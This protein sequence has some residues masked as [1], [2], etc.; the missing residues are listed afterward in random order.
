VQ[1]SRPAEIAPE[2]T[3]AKTLALI[4]PGAS[5]LCAGDHAI[6]V[7]C[8]LRERGDRVWCVASTAEALDEATACGAHTRVAD[9]EHEPLPA[10]VGE[11]RFDVVVIAGVLEH[12]RE[13][14]RVLQP[15]RDVLAPGGIVVASLPNFG[16]AGVRLATQG[17]VV[18]PRPAVDDERRARVFTRSGIEALVRECG[19][20]VQTIDRTALPDADGKPAASDDAHALEFVV[21]AIPVPGPWDAGAMRALVH[22]L[23]AR[24]DDVREALREAERA[25]SDAAAAASAANADAHERA[26]AL[27]AAGEHAA[28]LEEERRAATDAGRDADRRAESLAEA[29]AAATAERDA[30]VARA[31]ASADEL[32]SALAEG[33]ARAHAADDAVRAAEDARGRAATAEDRAAAA[34]ARAGAAGAR[35]DAAEARARD[36][37]ERANTAGAR[38]AAAEARAAEAESSAAAAETR[39][40]AA[41]ARAREAAAS[42][43]GARAQ[44]AAARAELESI[45]RTLA[46]AEEERDRLRGLEN[47]RQALLRLLDDDPAP[48]AGRQ[49]WSSDDG[50]TSN[51]KPSNSTTSSP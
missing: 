11:T 5:V 22:D 14:W 9:L 32:R 31:A 13:P 27:A 1:Q 50:A 48:L 20:S 2:T 30:A 4:P 28:R 41:E 29:L 33:T 21:R 40:T 38:A 39:A 7:A 19:F 51:E 16:H 24:L 37:D 8:A 17:G 43:D 36:A 45:R 25:R 15:A 44:A 23:Q 35:A 46:A 10:L 6:A 49:L 26:Q 18:P 34:E 42:A 3:V 47:R 12:A